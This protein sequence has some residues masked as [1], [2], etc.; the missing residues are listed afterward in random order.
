MRQYISTL[1]TL[2]FEL[3]G[4]EVV[5]ESPC[6][7]CVQSSRCVSARRLCIGSLL[8]VKVLSPIVYLSHILIFLFKKGLCQITLI[9]NALIELFVL[10][11]SGN[12]VGLKLLLLDDVAATSHNLVSLL[13]FEVLMAVIDGIAWAKIPQTAVHWRQLPYLVSDGACTL[14]VSLMLLIFYVLRIR[15]I[16]N[17]G[18]LSWVI[19]LSLIHPIICVTARSDS[20]MSLV[21]QGINLTGHAD[22]PRL[23]WA[24]K[25]PRRSQRPSWV[26][27]AESTQSGHTVLK[28]WLVESRIQV[29][30]GGAA[31]AGLVAVMD[32]ICLIH[33]HNNYELFYLIFLYC[34]D[35][36]LINNE[37]EN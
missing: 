27:S 29:V 35:A 7:D 12:W 24:P 5:R 4:Y 2:L 17:R 22:P 10:V 9:V 11:A 14:S 33:F 23:L 34:W 15:L 26:E 3:E 8:L 6:D 28:T 37:I 30:G 16:V 32:V 25:V 19:K 31:R 36:K 18:N 21:E 13:K 1:G 20:V